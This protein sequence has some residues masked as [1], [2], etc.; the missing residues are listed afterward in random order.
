MKNRKCCRRFKYKTQVF[1]SLDF[2]ILSCLLLVS[3]AYLVYYIFNVRE[4]TLCENINSVLISAAS[5]YIV[6]YFV[7]LLTVHIPGY[8]QIVNNERIICNFLSSYRDNLLYGF[9]GLTKKLQM[10]NSENVIEIQAVTE[11]FKSH[12]LKDSLKVQIIQNTCNSDN[13]NLLLAKDF[14]RLASAFL[15][16]VQINA[17][18]KSHFSHDINQLQID[19]WHEVLFIIKDELTKPKTGFDILKNQYVKDLIDKNFE[20]ANRGAELD[21]LLN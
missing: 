20:L 16:I 8:H 7:Y 11:L 18:Y 3:M 9:G 5:G 2:I 14:E 12:E 1:L 15:H 19:N 4:R 17:V 13:A 10:E 21:K 6:S